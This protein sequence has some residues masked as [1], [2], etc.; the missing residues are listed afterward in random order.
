MSPGFKWKNPPYEYETKKMPIDILAGTNRLR[1]MVDGGA[2]L[3][4]FSE[5]FESDAEKFQEERLA[6]AYA[7]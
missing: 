3:K 4:A 1:R 5:W 6:E 7:G 2:P